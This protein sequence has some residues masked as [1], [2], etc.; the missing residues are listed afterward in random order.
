MPP[1]IR[2][3]AW[4]IEAPISA[5]TVRLC[6]KI[7][8]D[9]LSPWLPHYKRHYS[10]NRRQFHAPLQPRGLGLWVV[11]C[12]LWVVGCKH[13]PQQQIPSSDQLH[14]RQHHSPSD[15]A[16]AEV[17]TAAHILETFVET[18]KDKGNSSSVTPVLCSKRAVKHLTVG[19][20]CKLVHQVIRRW[21]HFIS[22][23]QTLLVDH[24]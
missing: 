13:A 24:F 5:M 6:R 1:A 15:I 23:S 16:I 11:G 17:K 3:S 9:V 21:Q 10:D 4:T 12:G 14:H 2:V 22:R 18:L 20:R 8:I 7:L 19:L